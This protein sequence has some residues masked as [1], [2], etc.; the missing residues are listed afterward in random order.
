MERWLQLPCAAR[1]GVLCV[2][3]K[4]KNPAG[5]ACGILE[6]RT[7]WAAEGSGFLATSRLIVQFAWHRAVS[8]LRRC[9]DDSIQ[10]VQTIERT[11][12]ELKQRIGFRRLGAV[13]LKRGCRDSE[14]SKELSCF[15]AVRF[16][17]NDRPTPTHRS[18]KTKPTNDLEAGRP[19]R[20]CGVADRRV[21]GVGARPHRSGARYFK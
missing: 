3:L 9:R 4:H 8:S 17:F 2:A 7:P 16:E 5:Q 11:N 20:W 1:G 14:T 13:T 15:D 18:L 12:A 19:L 10:I 21:A 6:S